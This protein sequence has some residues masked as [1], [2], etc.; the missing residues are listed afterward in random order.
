MSYKPKTRYTFYVQLHRTNYNI[1]VMIDYPLI[2]STSLANDTQIDLFHF[3]FIQSFC[4][5]S[6][7]L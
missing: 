1:S 6:N 3:D 5:Y 4:Y 2:T 7:I